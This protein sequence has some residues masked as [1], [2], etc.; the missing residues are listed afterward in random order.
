VAYFLVSHLLVQLAGLV[1]VLTLVIVVVQQFLGLLVLLFVLEF[2][3]PV[4]SLA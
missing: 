2:D 1:V 3:L 4:V